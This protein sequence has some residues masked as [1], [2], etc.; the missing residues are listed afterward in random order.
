M[1][2]HDGTA[3]TWN[4][5]DVLTTDSSDQDNF[6]IAL[7]FSSD[8][9]TLVVGAPRTGPFGSS[10]ARALT[11]GEVYVYTRVGNK[12]VSVQNLTLPVQGERDRLGTQ[13]F[14]APDGSAIYA[15]SQAVYCEWGGCGAPRM[16]NRGIHTWRRNEGNSTYVYAGRAQ[17]AEPDI[18]H[19]QPGQAFAVNA[20]GSRMY[21]KSY[22]V[23]YIAEAKASTGGLYNPLTFATKVSVFAVNAT[24]D[25]EEVDALRAPSL[26]LAAQDYGAHMA[27]DPLLGD[28]YVSATRNDSTVFRYAPN[29]T[30]LQLFAE[31]NSELYDVSGLGDCNV[32]V[33]PWKT[34]G[35]YFGQDTSFSPNGQFMVIGA[36]F[37]VESAQGLGSVYLYTRNVGVSDNKWNLRET[38]KS[39]HVF[40]YKPAGFNIEGYNGTTYDPQIQQSIVDEFG[41]N[42]EMNDNFVVVG[43]VGLNQVHVF[44]N[45]APYPALPPPPPPAPPIAEIIIPP[46]PPSGGSI[47][48]ALILGLIGVLIFLIIMFFVARYAIKAYFKRKFEK[49]GVPDDGDEMDDLD[50]E[51][52]D[53]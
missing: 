49:E 19:T 21:V 23:D 35:T 3:D 51:D 1:Y 53:K 18:F 16:E 11:Y 45:L 43:A 33:Q 31:G 20:D 30:V 47:A 26:Y 42:V 29:N 37:G 12:Y 46:P 52:L 6:G 7:S 38:L 13:V 48:L 39:T 22:D 10:A 40:E 44:G 17:T 9:T 5:I 14:V 50:D 27:V 28:L 24:G 34:D 25:W 36:P 8:A 41:L 4:E 32:F 15:M 2:E